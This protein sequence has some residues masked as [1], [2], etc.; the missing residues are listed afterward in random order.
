M[1]YCIGIESGAR[2]STSWRG[3]RIARAALALSI[4]LFVCATRAFATTQILDEIVVDGRA[5]PLLSQPLGA[6]YPGMKSLQLEAKLQSTTTCSANWRRYK[7]YWKIEDSRLFLTR[8]VTD[9]CSRPP[10]EVAID[11][12][13]PGQSAPVLAS[14]YS[15]RLI[16]LSGPPGRRDFSPDQDPHVELS[17][18]AG[19]VV[20]ERRIPPPT[21][22]AD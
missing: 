19:S 16:V 9:A 21:R 20:G 10:K 4:V 1:R 17:V 2:R 12:V 18:V 3:L 13:V 22:R 14:W 15:G 5:L 7:A 6:L 8:V 11:T